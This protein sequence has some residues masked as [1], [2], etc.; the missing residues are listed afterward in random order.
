M[1]FRSLFIYGDNDLENV[2]WINYCYWITSENVVY[3]WH[4]FPDNYIDTSGLGGKLFV[5]EIDWD[6]PNEI[7]KVYILEW[8]D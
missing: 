8:F 2:V 5:G 4:H 7:K 6:N 1:L 3:L